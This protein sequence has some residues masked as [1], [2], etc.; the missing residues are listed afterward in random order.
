M[1]NYRKRIKKLI[2][3]SAAAG[4]TLSFL[5]G[6]SAPGQEESSEPVSE[7][8]G[9]SESFLNGTDEFSVNLLKEAASDPK[10]NGENILVSPESVLMALGMTAEGASGDTLSEMEQ[11]L[12]GGMSIKDF[13][14]SMQYE[15][16][17]EK[18]SK[19]VKFNIA[20]SVWIRDDSDRIRIKEDFLSRT[21]DYYSAETFKEDFN[22]DTLKK[23]NGW[24]N[25]N[26]DG[27][28]DNIIQEIPSSAVMYLINAIA[29]EGKWE[30]EYKDHQINE[31]DT[32]TN[33]KGEEEKACMLSSTENIY[34]EGKDVTGF[35]KKYKGGKYIFTALLPNEG[36]T[37]EECISDMTDKTFRELI[38]CESA[39]D[40]LVKIPEFE[41]DFSTSLKQYLSDMGIKSAFSGSADFSIMADSEGLFISDVIH[42]THIELNRKGTKASASTA[43]IMKDGAAPGHEEEPKQVY[44]DRPFVYAIYNNETG[45]PVFMGVVNSIKDK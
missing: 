4:M 7:L 43:V 6:C 32:F 8:T 9:L 29:F 11:V 38:D 19:D 31:D 22:N 26:T 36:I 17:N 3:L 14:S 28:I 13:S 18:A 34:L 30:E 12:A 39:E 35:I 33:S 20:N 41:Y 16:Q 44:L 10:Y 27:M 42:K 24:V 40:V 37:L 1:K 23:I 45:M 21:K 15:L 2:S 25:D 5:C